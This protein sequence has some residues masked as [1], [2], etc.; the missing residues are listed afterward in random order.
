MSG[1]TFDNNTAASLIAAGSMVG[2]GQVLTACSNSFNYNM[3]QAGSK[4]NAAINVL[5][6][7]TNPY[8]K[9]DTV[10]CDSSFT[11]NSV[12]SVAINRF[13]SVLINNNTFEENNA[14]SLILDSVNAE[15]L[16]APRVATVSA[17]EF[18]EYASRAHS[19]HRCAIA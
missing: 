17:N 13:Q 5:Q 3:P 7:A 11:H 6:T 2:A 15:A 10:V 4:Y 12:P 19:P 8:P 18:S 1:N 14:Y 16:A 9:Y